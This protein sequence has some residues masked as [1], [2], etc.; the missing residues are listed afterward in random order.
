MVIAISILASAALAAGP[1]EP[2]GGEWQKQIA[3]LETRLFE[4]VLAADEVDRLLQQLK[5]PEARAKAAARLAE[6]GQGHAD[7]VVAFAHDCPDME[8]RQA[9]VEIVEAL[10]AAYRTSAPGKQLGALYRKHT[11]A[12]LPNYWAR[13][14]KDPLDRRA[15]AMLMH[16]DAEKAYAA[17]GKTGDRHDQVRYLLLRVGEL[18]PDEF[19][20][21]HIFEHTASGANLVMADVFP[22][23]GYR[24]IVGQVGLSKIIVGTYNANTGGLPKID[25]LNVC[26]RT[27]YVFSYHSFNGVRHPGGNA[28]DLQLK[29]VQRGPAGGSQGRVVAGRRLPPAGVEVE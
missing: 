15:V 4:P 2:A 16:A 27:V 8:A 11:E 3:E 20:R 1:S 18:T 22:H 5:L 21:K 6:Q 24:R 14:R 25:Y 19:A 9:C 26:Q 13:F 29:G 12:L 10:D 17:L 23:A 28:A 7:R